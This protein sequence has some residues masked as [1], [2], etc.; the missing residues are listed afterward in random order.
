VAVY[1]LLNDKIVP[2]P[3]GPGIDDAICAGWYRNEQILMYTERQR[4]LTF[5]AINITTG[6]R[7]EVNAIRLPFAPGFQARVRLAAG[8]I[9]SRADAITPV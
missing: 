1:D 6:E 3:T 4:V 7:H 5:H 9:A 2:V 8:V